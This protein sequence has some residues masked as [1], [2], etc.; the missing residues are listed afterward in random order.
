[1][2]TISLIG[3]F[4][5]TFALLSYGVGNITLQRFKEISKSTLMFFTLGTL[6]DVMAIIFMI[7]GA[8]NTPYTF[9]GVLGYSSFVIISVSVFLIWREFFKV[10]FYVKLR[11][12]V[13]LY[14]RMAYLYWVITYLTGSILIMVK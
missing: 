10:G 12:K 13:L 7:K 11:P 6:L 9:H 14:A 8:Q 5:I 3:A 1:M 4:L 2:E